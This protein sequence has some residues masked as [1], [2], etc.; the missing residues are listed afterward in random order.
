[1]RVCPKWLICDLINIMRADLPVDQYR[2]A[3]LPVKGL[4]D[5]HKIRCGP[6]AGTVI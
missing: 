6:G 2:W 1:M 4:L 3:R 5:T